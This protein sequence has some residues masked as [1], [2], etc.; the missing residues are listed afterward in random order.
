MILHE[1]A[2][3]ARPAGVTAIA[4][5]CLVLAGLQ[6]AFALLAWG[7]QVAL[8]RG[9]FLVGAGLEI[10]GPV[11][12][13]VFAF[14]F[15]RAGFGLLFLSC[16]SR[17]LTILLAALGIYLLVPTVSS[18]VVDFRLRSLAIEGVQMIVRV[19]VVWYLMQEPVSE[20]FEHAASARKRKLF[21]A[22]TRG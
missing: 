21:A 16:W 8:A 3:T 10:Y 19:G 11:M 18:A 1:P 20:A 15:A 13:L 9:A 17:Y 5:V 7:G 2:R 12:F 14:L 4:V 22:D 6:F